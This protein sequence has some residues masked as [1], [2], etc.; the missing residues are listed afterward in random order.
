LITYFFTNKSFVDKTNS[1]WKR[2]VQNK[3]FMDS[4]RFCWKI[5]WVYKGFDCKINC[6]LN[7]FRLYLEKIKVNS[8][9]I[10]TRV[11]KI[12]REWEIFVKYSHVIFKSQFVF[13]ANVFFNYFKS[14]WV[15]TWEVKIIIKKY[16]IK[17]W[18]KIWIV[19]TLINLSNL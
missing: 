7:Q 1:I 18:F 16:S 4:I 8:D 19:S 12:S 3:M 9:K 15:S 14:M 10:I 13:S 6:F 2:K 5:Y 11:E 17:T